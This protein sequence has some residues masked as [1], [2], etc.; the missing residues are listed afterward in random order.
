M[1][2][3]ILPNVEAKLCQNTENIDCL[4]MFIACPSQS[5]TLLCIIPF[6]SERLF[7]VAEEL[8]LEWNL[9]PSLNE[10]HRTHEANSYCF[11]KY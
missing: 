1:L 8:K 10:Y 5:L 7:L 4:I 6:I 2:V 3:Y 9:V 11:K